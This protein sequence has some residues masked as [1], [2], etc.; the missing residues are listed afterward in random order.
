MKYIIVLM[1]L[2]GCAQLKIV[3]DCNRVE[4]VDLSVCEGLW[5]WE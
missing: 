2:S 5:F 3:R 1:L 4:N